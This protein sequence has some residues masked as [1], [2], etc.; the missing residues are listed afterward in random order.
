MSKR[1]TQQRR[2][3]IITDLNLS[4]E[5]S[6]DSLAKQFDISEVSIR[7]DL[8]ALENSGLLLRRYGGAIAL[9]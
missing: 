2:H 8:A 1:N 3:H 4:G 6:V 9:P 5:V 7:K